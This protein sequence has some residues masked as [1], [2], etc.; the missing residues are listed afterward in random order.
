MLK[1]LNLGVRLFSKVLFYFWFHSQAQ[2]NNLSL[3]FNLSGCT[4][5]FGFRISDFL[6]PTSYFLLPTSNFGFRIF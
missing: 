1:S 6:N 2:A 3:M 5:D 4:I